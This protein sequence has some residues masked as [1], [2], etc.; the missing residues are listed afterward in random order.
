MPST[1]GWLDIVRKQPSYCTGETCDEAQTGVSP[2]HDA[3]GLSN[4]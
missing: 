4:D 1:E 2:P 3:Y